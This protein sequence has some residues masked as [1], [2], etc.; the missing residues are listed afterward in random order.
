[1]KYRTLGRTGLKVS[2]I[3]FG[4]WAIGGD[5]HIGGKTVGWGYNPDDA[6]SARALKVALDHG[7]NFFDTADMY[8]SGHSEEVIG[9]TF[10]PEERGKIIIA[11]KFGNKTG[12]DGTW[13]KNFSPSYLVE[14]LE[15]SLRR[16]RTDYLDVY[17]LHTPG[18][19]L[20]IASLEKTFAALEKLKQSG[21]IRFYGTSIGP[22]SHGIELIK[23]NWGDLL[24]VKYN[25]LEPEADLELFPLA[26]KHNIGIIIREAL[27]AGFL[28]GKYTKDF[29]FAPTD[30]RSF[31]YSATQK[32]DWFAKID[33]WK[34]ELPTG[35]SLTHYALKWVLEKDAV[36]TIIAG[37][38]S[39][40]QILDSIQ[41]S[42]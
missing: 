4:A 39:K 5:A 36:S 30:H 42:R 24:Q 38:K 23:Y 1:M 35:T 9:K 27:C 25:L 14:A 40:E 8:G 21:K 22:V 11:S 16:L 29:K 12:P 10:S 28:T 2:E 17:Q 33:V 6:V 19:E 32:A 37:A 7:V 15:A 41:T 13:E 20:A 34:K 18:P 26:Q 3:G 31:R